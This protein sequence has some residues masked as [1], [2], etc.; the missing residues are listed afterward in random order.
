MCLEKVMESLQWDSTEWL[1]RDVIHDNG[2]ARV[3][4]VAGY[5]TSKALLASSIPQL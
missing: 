4:D 5:Q 2:N 1:T 3:S